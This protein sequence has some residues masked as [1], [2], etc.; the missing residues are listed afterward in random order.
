MALTPAASA[1]VARTRAS[2]VFRKALRWSAARLRRAAPW[3]Q[4]AHHDDGRA[5]AKPAPRCEHLAAANCARAAHARDGRPARASRGG[6]RHPLSAGSAAAWWPVGATTQRAL[7]RLT[8][9]ALLRCRRI[10]AAGPAIA[11]R[12][13]ALSSFWLR[14]R[15]DYGHDRRFGSGRPGWRGAGDGRGRQAQ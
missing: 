9:D 8:S 15:D 2:I 4:H 3:H 12:R 5:A 14:R 1:I 11:P 6:T 7:Q 10:D 13:L